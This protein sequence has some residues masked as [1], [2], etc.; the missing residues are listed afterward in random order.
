MPKPRFTIREI[1]ERIFAIDDRES[2]VATISS[3]GDVDW[4]LRSPL[5]KGLKFESVRKETHLAYT[6]GLKFHLTTLT[7]ATVLQKLTWT[8]EQNE[9]RLILSAESASPDG[10]W[11]A[12]TIATLHTDQA[13]SEYVW[14]FETTWTCLAKSALKLGTVEYNNVYPAK[15]GKCFLCAPDK[16]YHF[17]LM[18]DRDGMVWNLPHQHMMHYTAKITPMRFGDGSLA[19][20]FGEEAGAPVVILKRAPVEPEWGIC[21]MYYDLHCQARVHRD[22]QPGEQLRFEYE[23]KYLNKVEAKKLLSASKV[24]PVDDKDR[25]RHH[26][27]RIE[28]GLN[29]FDQPCHIDRPDEASGFRPRPP[30]KVWDREVGNRGKG[31]LRLTHDGPGELVWVSEPPTLIPAKTRLKIEAKV[32]TQNVQGKGA[33]VRI[34]YH[35]WQFLPTP[36]VEWKTQLE[37]VPVNATTDGWTHVAMPTLHVPE[38]DFDFLIQ[39]EVVLDGSGVAWVTDV[40]VDL[41]PLPDEAPKAEVGSAKKGRRVRQSAGTSGA[42]EI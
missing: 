38:E 42:G 9:S 7:P 19:G 13:I 21:D 30:Q 2:T 24:V 18:T 28:L 27:P 8:F 26:Y 32:K 12:K 22:I 37:T 15:A 5:Q 39:L 6:L 34:K 14:Q 3:H 11:G 1:G 41:S 31:S 23:V 29:C 35:T 16:E 4:V 36:H 20:F 33:F 40:D 25:E 17:T 10:N